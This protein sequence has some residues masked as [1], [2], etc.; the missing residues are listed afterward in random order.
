LRAAPG[1]SLIFSFGP[2]PLAVRC[3]WSLKNAK[4]DETIRQRFASLV[5]QALASALGWV[6]DA[7]SQPAELIVPGQF[8]R[9]PLRGQAQAFAGAAQARALAMIDGGGSASARGS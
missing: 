5:D 4:I 3:A 7:A 2:A 6:G 9:N 1:P 8:T